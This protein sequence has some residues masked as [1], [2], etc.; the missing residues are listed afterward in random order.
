MAH[1][2]VCNHQEG[3]GGG[4][5]MPTIGPLQHQDSKACQQVVGSQV[6]SQL[7][8][9]A[10]DWLA[11]SF[12]KQGGKSYEKLIINFILVAIGCLPVE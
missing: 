11:P 10:D 1:N 2:M 3:T 9:D 4:E 5:Q 6:I 12:D 7:T 8:V